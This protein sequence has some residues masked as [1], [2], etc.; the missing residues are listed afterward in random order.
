MS[1]TEHVNEHYQRLLLLASPW[2][3]T[4]VEEDLA[5]NCV[6][7]VVGHD[8]G[9]KF[10]C[11]E[12][13]TQAPVYDPAPVRS[14]RHL[15]VMQYRLE[16]ACAVPR[17]HC[18][19]HGIRNVSVPWSGSHSRFTFL[20]EDFAVRI[21]LAS[22]SLTQASEIL[23][24]S[25]NA[26]QGI[27]NRAVERGL[28]RREKEGIERVGIDEKS[29][30]R[31][32]SYVSSMADLEGRR[33]L[34]VVEG[35]DA[36]SV[37]ALWK[38]FIEWQGEEEALKVKACAMDMGRSMIAG[39]RRSVPHVAIVHDKFHV[40]K[41]VNEG[42]DKTRRQEHSALRQKGDSLLSGTRYLFLYREVP[43]KRKEEFESLLKA[44]GKTANAWKYKEQMEHF[45]D[46]EDKEEGES[47][48]KKW[49]S[50]VEQT[51]LTHM[52]KVAET[53]RTHMDNLLNYFTHPITNAMS[54][55][56]NSKIQA[57]KSAARGFRSFR[58]YR[59]RILFFCG[60]LDMSPL[61]STH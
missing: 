59:A 9:A 24:V 36:A 13:S 44:N 58:N 1:S 12:C 21:L 25:W 52:K 3:V 61:P 49:I 15:S 26:L 34:E 19:E 43:D 48:L 47:W 54:E 11:P 51:A 27:I 37:K 18:P 20:F 2:K 46:R 56:F 42:V 41:L 45:W 6:R 50:R 31:G 22:A 7:L 38:S 33:V 10:P 32:Q 28:L 57:L 40:S 23:G 29:F 8:E 30:L 39:T 53:L 55:G 5:Q 16:I 17:C 35:N 14:W 60:R 4:R